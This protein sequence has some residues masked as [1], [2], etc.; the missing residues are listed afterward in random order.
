MAI[1]NNILECIGST[2]VVKLNR[3]APPHVDLYVK[4]EAA[5]PMSSV[6]DR[7][8]LG[9][10]EAAERDGK[11]QPGQTVIE[12]TS[13]N[14]GIGLAMVCAQ[15][16]YPL[17]IVMAES[18]SVERRKLMR[19]LGAKVVLTPAAAKGSGMVAKARELA[20]E[21]GWFLCRQFENPANTEVH[22]RTTAQEILDDFGPDGLDVFVSGVGTGG[23]LNGVARRLKADSPKTRIIACEPDNS[24]VLRGFREQIVGPDGSPAASHP[25]FRPHPVQGWSPDFVSKL[26]SEALDS[27]LVD[28]IV[29]INGHDAIELS[30]RL[31]REEGI[32]CGTSSG[33]TLAAALDVANRS[34]AGTKILCMLP[35]TGERYQSTILFEGIEADMSE[36]EWTIARSTDNYRFDAPPVQVDRPADVVPIAPA[37]AAAEIDRMIAGCSEPVMMFAL[38]WCEFCWSAQRLL[39]RLGIGWQAV[40]LDR[41]EWQGERGRTMRQALHARTGGPTLPQIWIGDHHLGGCTDLFDAL[42]NGSLPDLIAAS[43]GTFKL[44]EPIDPSSFLPRWMQRRSG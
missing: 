34:L 10:I 13:G 28:E 24:P 41:P 3:L 14:T 19:Y 22:M 18:F 40:N 5:N 25:D 8:A 31:A 16:G 37:A 7:L 44:R 29:S 2:P 17:V 4:L 27:G 26:A 42:E 6:K 32:F 23:T 43:G 1:K 11:L 36:A 20:E 12:A 35:D 15:R 39:D 33:A 30:R 21:H 9:I 38:E